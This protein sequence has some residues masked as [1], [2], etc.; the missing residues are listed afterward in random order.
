[1][2][3]EA[4][5]GNPRLA[6]VIGSGS[7]KCA[8]ALGLWKV[9]KREGIELDMVVGCSGGS[10]YAAGIALGGDPQHF[11]EM[12]LNFWTNDLMS[13]YAS[14]LRAVMA[15]EMRFDETSGLVDDE[16]VMERL[17]RAFGGRSFADT[18]TP[19]YLVATDFNSGDKVVMTEGALTDAIRASIAIPMIFPPWRVDG[20]LLTDGAVSDPLPVDVA[21]REGA[22]IIL[23]M[24]FELPYRKRMRS[25]NAVQSHLNAMYMNN[26]LRATYA[27]YN[28]VHHQEIIS[29]WPDFDRAISGFSTEQIPYIIE[30]GERTA[31]EH[32]PYL[33]RLLHE[34]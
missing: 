10:L 30:E 23:A 8:A 6:L 17:Q 11:E 34:A 2:S 31:E 16:P 7:V 9:L 12:T 29:L 5:N 33:Q 32:L 14:N 20:K 24:G 13:G 1:M 15:R 21:I 25:F 18:D 3:I 4:K 26:I 28:A 22:Q 27:F 19:L